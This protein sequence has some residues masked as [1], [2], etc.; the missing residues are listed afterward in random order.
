MD[1]IFWTGMGIAFILI[2][3]QAFRPVR[4]NYGAITIRTGPKVNV[5]LGSYNDKVK[6]GTKRE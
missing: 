3:V 2:C 6:K 4:K 5:D 1:T